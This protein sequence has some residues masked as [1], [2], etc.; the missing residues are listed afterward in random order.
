MLSSSPSSAPAPV[1]VWPRTF[2]SDGRGLTV[3]RPATIAQAPSRPRVLEIDIARGILLFLMIST[4][5]V[6]LSG[7]SEESLFKSSWWLPRGWGTAGFIILSGFSV[8]VIVGADRARLQ[9]TRIRARR[10]LLVALASNV[11]FVAAKYAV[12]GRLANLL[13]PG[14]WWGVVTM[15][16]DPSIS[17]ILL[18]TSLALTVMPPLVRIKQR[19]SIAGLACVVLPLFVGAWML[20][21]HGASVMPANALMDMLLFGGVAGFPILPLAAS[22]GAG[23]LI[24]FCWRHLVQEC[25]APMM[26]WVYGA[27]AVMYLAS[28]Q[29][30]FVHPFS[31]LL[32][33]L[34]VIGVAWLISTMPLVRQPLALLG[35]QSLFVFLTHRAIMHAAVFASAR[36]GVPPSWRYVMTTTVVVLTILMLCGLRA[37]IRDFD[38][39]CRAVYL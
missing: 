30:A 38:R 31:A 28:T 37:R 16:I 15:R 14:C 25:P 19:W 20:H 21:D 32:R 23:L 9:A 5:A 33:V 17:A 11:V 3:D 36:A 12:T 27:A 24:G 7:V 39:L 35:G 4:H 26:M 6:L 22:A 18:P 8:A 10:L 34:I 1:L 13:D 29:I 2:P